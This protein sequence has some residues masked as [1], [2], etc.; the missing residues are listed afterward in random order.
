MSKAYLFLLAL[1]ALAALG[2]GGFAYLR[3]TSSSTTPSYSTPTTT[4]QAPSQ[5]TT[6]SQPA[7][8][9][10]LQN[11]IALTVS[12]PT[13]GQQVSLASLVV[14]GKTAPNAD[15]AVN[16]KDIKADA[17]GN[18]QTTITLDEGDNEIFI[19][20][21]DANGNYSEWSATVTYTPAQ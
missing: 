13:K 15:V 7:T 16:D 18:F 4:P 8:E 9:A 12:S 21:S 10:P 6:P 3:S 14:K 19:T 20:A 5:P 2:I 17:S 11:Q 1:L